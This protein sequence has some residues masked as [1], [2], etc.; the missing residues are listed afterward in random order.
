MSNLSANTYLRNCDE[1]EYTHS[2]P[3][4]MTLNVPD[5][6]KNYQ[7]I[8]SDEKYSN[9][10]I[11]DGDTSYFETFS[12]CVYYW[13]NDVFKRTDV[14]MFSYF[15]S[16]K[17]YGKRF[18]RKYS[19]FLDGDKFHN[20]TTLFRGV[21]FEAVRQYNGVEKR[22]DEYND[23][24]FSFIY[25]P[26]ALK[27]IIFN[28]T[29]HFVKNDTFKFIVGIVFVNTMLGMYDHNIFSG[30]VDYFNKGFLY[31]ACKDIIRPENTERY[32][33]NLSISY[34]SDK[35]D[36]DDVDINGVYSDVW[37][38]NYDIKEEI[39]RFYMWISD[40]RK[41]VI[42]TKGTGYAKDIVLDRDIIGEFDI[43]YGSEDVLGEGIENIKKSETKYILFE[44]PNSED[45][46]KVSISKY[47]EEYDATIYRFKVFTYYGNIVCRVNAPHL[48]YENI[49]LVDVCDIEWKYYDD[50]GFGYIV[51]VSELTFT[52]QT[53][54]KILV[55]MGE[56]CVIS[57]KFYNV[58]TFDPDD[59]SNDTKTVEREFIN[60]EN[61]KIVV[62]VNNGSI[63]ISGTNTILEA[64]DNEV[65]ENLRM[66]IVIKDNY[67][68][69][70][71]SLALK[72][73]FEVFKELS[74]YNI[75]E[76]IN[77]DFNIKYYSTVEDNKYKIRVIE[78]DS[79]EIED[80]YEAIP[81]KITQNNKSVVGSVDIKEKRDIDKIGIKIINRY[82]GFYNPIFNDILYYDD[83]V[84]SVPVGRLKNVVNFDLPYSNTNID[85]NYND[86]Y[87]EFGVIRNMYYHKTNT[88]RSDKILTSEKP[89]YPAINEYA[90]DYRDYNIFSSSWDEGYFISQD[91]LDTRSI[92][93]GIGSMKDTLCMFGSK[94]LNIPDYIF[95][96][97][98]E[99]GK[100][101]NEKMVMDI[102]D[103]TDTEIMYKEINNRTVKYHLFIEKRLK[104]YL[105]ENLMRVFEKY[106]NKE[107]SF[108]NKGTI[109]DDVDEYVEKNLLKLYKV[110]KI[111][112][113]IKS[114]RMSI[115]DR[116]I[117]NEY[118]KYMNKS[119]EVK[120]KNGFPVI[121]VDG[122]GKMLVDSKF[123]MGKINEF[124]RFVTYNLKPGFK[125]SFG[126]GVS[127]K[128]K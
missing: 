73:Y 48:L 33:Y 34:N 63:S 26:V 68:D 127:F 4:Y 25:I 102:R 78:P 83:Y 13:I 75:T 17:K 65:I 114:D 89:V 53:L 79:I 81:V 57:I 19:R 14:D 50:S 15:F 70:L 45:D 92:C 106:I 12:D 60:E 117:E 76:S 31:A 96:D 74:M 99:N 120:I 30:K 2:M 3:Y 36:K 7:Y 8:Y 77:N 18:D 115:N 9:H 116:V 1:S 6:Q 71:E 108:G 42:V 86:G 118:L 125:E 88:S 55:S 72:D 121:N 67:N 87:G 51:D 32:N 82:S 40:D 5:Y 43:E 21:K 52:S 113:Y 100:Y 110:D 54:Q 119:N 27:S 80:R 103:N 38:D 111:Y 91:D 64:Y 124:D 112:M 22:S 109:E 98:F 95:I 10:Y 122:D 126:F 101:W 24:R 85:Y 107:Y 46:F 90:L 49:P 44:Q 123:I 16:G 23:Y 39:N 56:D 29:V 47:H 37:E 128:R 94:Y 104:R 58:D 35:F 41:S 28:N 93:D 62:D 20:P 97:T 69:N 61:A 11:G 66:D 105:K 59:P 84:Y